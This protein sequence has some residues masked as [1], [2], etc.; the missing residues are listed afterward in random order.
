MFYLKSDQESKEMIKNFWEN[1]IEYLV[2]IRIL[3]KV[4]PDFSITKLESRG[5][6]KM[7]K[8]ISLSDKKEIFQDQYK[9]QI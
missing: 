2:K 3:L 9:Y 7:W 6:G 8:A 4:F 1:D 5:I